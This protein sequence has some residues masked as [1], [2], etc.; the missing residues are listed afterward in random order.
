MTHRG[1]AQLVRLAELS[2]LIIGLAMMTTLAGTSAF[3]QT[4]IDPTGRSGQP[5][6]PLK[7]EFQ[8]P[9]PPPSPVL[10]I[11]PLPPEG[12]APRK[13]GAVQIFVRDIMVTGNTVFSDAE[14]NEVTAPY[15][16][17]TLATEDLERLRLALTLLY[18]QQRLPDLRRDHPGSGG[19]GRCR[20]GAHH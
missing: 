14:I 18:H 9:H 20:G 6:G 11:V 5:P 2:S 7:E 4:A 1:R 13:P 19:A 15:K 3:A 12:E 17:R 16:N 10:P 8:R